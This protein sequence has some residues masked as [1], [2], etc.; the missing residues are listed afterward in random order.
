MVA[1][2]VRPPDRA[3]T[4]E[5][6]ERILAA[7][8]SELFAGCGVVFDAGSEGFLMGMGQSWADEVSLNRFLKKISER[9]RELAQV[10]RQKEQAADIERT[11]FYVQHKIRILTDFSDEITRDWRTRSET[12]KR[13]LTSLSAT[14]SALG[15]SGFNME[16]LHNCVV[17]FGEKRGP[18][19][20]GR[21]HLHIQD[22]SAKWLDILKMVDPAKARE[23][24]EAARM[25]SETEKALAKRL[26][27]AFFYSDYSV[28]ASFQYLFYIESIR[29]AFDTDPTRAAAFCDMADVKLR[30]SERAP[31]A[32]YAD[33]GMTVDVPSCT[34]VVP[35]DTPHDRLFAFVAKNGPPLVRQHRH[36]MQ[37]AEAQHQVLLRIKRK[38]MLA[39]LLTDPSLRFE[40]VESCCRRLANHAA[41]LGNLLQG[42]RIFIGHEYD[43]KQADGTLSIRWNWLL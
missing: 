30:I 5:Q 17:V 21:V 36:H 38:F 19:I 4:P 15:A 39:S 28:A 40:Q 27:F 29:K 31:L 20:L 6:L 7:Q 12:E 14:L 10:R 43:V 11:M 41:L 16:L 18:D 24:R 35:M 25:R 42:Q 37:V 13:L 26:G 8:L 9:C 3:A 23:I 1:V 32:D 34:V 2:Y 33:A 22:S